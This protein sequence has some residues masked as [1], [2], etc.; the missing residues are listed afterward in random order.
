MKQILICIFLFAGFALCGQNT[1][2]AKSDFDFIYYLIG[3][4]FKEDALAIVRNKDVKPSLNTP[5]ADSMHFISGWTYYSC[6]KL[7]SASLMLDLVSDFSP[8]HVQSRLFSC[9]S[10][11]HGG[12]YA[13]ARSAL[14][15][16]KSEDNGILQLKT[17]TQGALA[18]LERNIGEFDSCFALLN[19]HDMRFESEKA[20]LLSLRN[21]INAHKP[22]SLWL[23]GALSSVVPGLG[24]VYAGNL[25]EGISAFLMTGSF[26]AATAEN[27]YR[28]GF[29]NWKTLVFATFSAVFYTG[30]IY[31]SVSAAKMSNVIF[32]GKKDVQI[33]YNIHIPIRNG[34]RH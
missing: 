33:L 14:N 26:M 28:K 19:T 10:Y 4:D 9:L 24:K 7:D 5:Y 34:F 18:L 2:Y 3:N 8:L 20:E 6:H 27:W 15:G 25:G 29:T 11:A 30:N 12:Q 17:Y 13:K 32:N 23:A 1:Q 21:E 31:G 22:K 16:L